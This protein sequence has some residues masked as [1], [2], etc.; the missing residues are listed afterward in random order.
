MSILTLTSSQWRLQIDPNQGMR[1]LSGD[2]F[3]DGSWIPVL[4][5]CTD[6]KID[7]K[8]CNYLLLPYSNRIR[9]GH[10]EF[11]GHSYQLDNA[12]KHAIHGTLRDQPWQLE[13][14]NDS[15]VTATFDSRDGQTINWP[16]PLA[17]RCDITLQENVLSCELQVQ[18]LGTSVM[19][20]GGGWH[21]YF[22]RQLLA[23]DPMLTI[24]VTGLYPDTNGDCL[25]IG[26][27]ID[28]PAILDFT[29]MRILDPSQR[30]DHC[31]KGLSD[32]MQIHW[33]DANVT[34]TMTASKNCSH[35]VLYNPDQP[36][37]ALEPVTHAND[38]VNLLTDGIEAGLELLEPDSIW[39][40]SLEI[41]IS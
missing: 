37:F 40:A 17:A 23:A 28:L 16:W 11:Q 6:P 8:E 13:Q 38:A 25:P 39:R 3:H 5:D 20:I 34:L 32:P 10:F 26:D 21:P 15:S 19:P 30:I 18:N 12:Q 27:A 24:P 29:D 22:V 41:R 9:D 31:F 36:W 4:P 14:L 33:P 7:L 35:A 2:L 1:W